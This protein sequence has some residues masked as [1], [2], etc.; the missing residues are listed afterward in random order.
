MLV[1]VLPTLPLG[2]LEF[3]DEFFNDNVEPDCADNGELL[4]DITDEAFWDIAEKA[5]AAIFA[6][7]CALDAIELTF[8]L[9]EK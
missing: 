5:A 7:A 1:L 4:E 9:D 2:L 6:L 8:L 3:K